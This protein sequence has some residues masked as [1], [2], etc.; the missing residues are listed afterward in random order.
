MGDARPLVPSL[1]TSARTLPKDGVKGHM[2]R[3]M[4]G[5]ARTLHRECFFLPCQLHP[6]M[7][8]TSQAPPEAGAARVGHA[9]A[10]CQGGA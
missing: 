3:E 8:Q 6:R 4:P 9:M 5:K 1:G 10:L 2:I 7:G